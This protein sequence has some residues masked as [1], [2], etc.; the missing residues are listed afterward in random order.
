MKTTKMIPISY[1]F[2]VTKAINE[3]LKI[4]KEYQNKNIYFFG[5]LVHNEN[6]IN[7]FKT[8]KI[9]VVPFT[10]ED[11]ISILE[12][13]NKDDIVIFSA[14]GHDSKY[15]EILINNGVTYFDTT[16]IRVKKNLEIIKN[17]HKEI[18]FIGKEKHPET[19][20]CL[21]YSKNI[22]LYD[23]SNKYNFDYSKLKTDCPLILNQT[24]LS[25]LELKDIFNE[26]KD[27]VKNPEFIDEICDASRV[28]QQ[29]ILNLPTGVDL[30]VVVGSKK[31]SNS[32][33]LYELSLTNN[34][35]V[36]TIMVNSLEELKT[37]DLSNY[38]DALIASGTSTPL[39]TINEIENYLNAKE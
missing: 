7:F 12:K 10:K 15:E 21:S 31:S 29:K 11:A 39:N 6:V 23:A 16:C 3:A 5:D 35:N 27:N 36:K 1:C 9:V 30:V 26:I 19:I 2:G 32:T 14:H 34:K 8:L 33:K 24:T 37:Y 25:F 4:R 18:I 20:A 28:R 17:A 13:F 38:H 22:H